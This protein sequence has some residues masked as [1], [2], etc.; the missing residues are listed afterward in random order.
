MCWA[1]LVEARGMVR[2]Q[3]AAAEAGQ[4][5]PW[6]DDR[7]TAPMSGRHE[8]SGQ[9]R[10]NQS[11]R[12]STAAGRHHEHSRPVD[13]RSHLRGRRGYGKRTW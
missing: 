13:G 11:H 9:A 8:R 1:G 12:R 6:R 7:Q 3:D 10:R 5:T 4:E 2:A